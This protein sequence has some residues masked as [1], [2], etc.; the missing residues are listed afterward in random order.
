MLARI[1]LL[2]TFVTS[3]EIFYR[4]VFFV[5][6]VNSFE[7]FVFKSNS[8]KEKLTLLRVP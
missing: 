5:A 4:I 3:K 8:L 1:T 6:F 7:A 2:K